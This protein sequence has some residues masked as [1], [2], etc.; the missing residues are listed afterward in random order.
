MTEH[1]KIGYCAVDSGFLVIVDP[2]YVE[3]ESDIKKTVTESRLGCIVKGFGG[4]GQYPVF[5][6]KD[7]SGLVTAVSVRFDNSDYER[8]IGAGLALAQNTTMLALLERCLETI[9]DY[10]SRHPSEEHFAEIVND[11]KTLL[12]N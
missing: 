4:D 6:E 5:I 8:F 9:E 3:G 1:E 10:S 11:I 12:R 7:D 2:C